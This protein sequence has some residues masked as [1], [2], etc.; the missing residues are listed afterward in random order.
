MSNTF[1]IAEAGSRTVMNNK[2]CNPPQSMS[3]MCLVA[4]GSTVVRCSW[5]LPV[6][7]GPYVGFQEGMSPT[8][9]QNTDECVLRLEGI[10]SQSTSTFWENGQ[11]LGFNSQ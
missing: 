5:M 9:W 7:Q 11:V 2:V 3:M 1:L 8:V 6:V 4:P 10:W